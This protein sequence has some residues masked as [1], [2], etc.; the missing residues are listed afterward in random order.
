MRILFLAAILIVWDIGS[1]KAETL[2]DCHKGVAAE[3]AGDLELAIASFTRCIDEGNLTMANMASAYYNRANAYEQRGR[4]D[5][6]I[7]DYNEVI[8]L[9]PGYGPAYVNRANA[10]QGN[11]DYDQAIQAYDE[12]IRRSPN[13]V[14]AYYNRGNAYER[15]GE[16][17]QAIKDYDAVISLDPAYGPAYIN[18]ANA[19]QE[20]GPYD[21]AIEDYDRAIRLN[22]GNAHAYY[23]RG[24]AY[25]NK[26]DQGRALQEFNEAIRLNPSYAAAPYAQPV[27]TEEEPQAKPSSVS[28]PPTAQEIEIAPAGLPED[29][30]E[31][32][33]AHLASLRTEEATEVG[34]KKLQ[35]QFPELLGQRELI[36]R[37]VQIEE[38]GT[39]FRI[40]TGPFQDRTKAQDLCAEFKALEQYCMVIRLTDAR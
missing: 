1:A 25:R 31:S 27:A 39:F 35:S 14:P 18:R 38:Q 5:Q 32:F 10:Y 21:R 28:S 2:V 23:S 40:M 22:P 13:F 33:A 20:K 7:R 8:Y 9:D 16:L 24:L 26:G 19:Y 30:R 11:G 15:K 29:D 36:V 6:A 3:E 37:S 4:Y 34:W 12:I 17:D